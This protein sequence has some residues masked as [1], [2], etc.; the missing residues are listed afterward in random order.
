MKYAH[1]AYISD[2]YF[3]S[4]GW[5]YLRWYTRCATH[6]KIFCSKVAKST[7]KMWNP[8]L[9]RSMQT[10]PPP[11][12]S[13]P[14]VSIFW[15]KLLCKQMWN[16]L[17]KIYFLSC[18]WFCSQ[19]S[20]VF[21]RNKIAHLMGCAMF[22]KRFLYSW[23]FFVRFLVSEMWL[24]LYSTVI[25]RELGSEK[26]LE[27]ILANLIQTLTSEARVLNPKAFRAQWHSPVRRCGVPK[28]FRSLAGPPFGT[29]RFPLCP[30][31]VIMSIWLRM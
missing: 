10:P 5:S 16:Q 2:F 28:N 15:S 1:N 29:V 4:Y 21:N 25:N 18:L 19:C 31:T 8:V 6:Q 11:P 24:I 14:A 12:S 13:K 27:E 22:C 20:S 30:M 7:E 26:K 17:S 9:V 23:I 3:L